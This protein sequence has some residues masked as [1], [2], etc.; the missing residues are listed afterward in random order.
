[1]VSFNEG[2]NVFNSGVYLR[3]GFVMNIDGDYLSYCLETK[4]LNKYR[5]LYWHLNQTSNKQYINQKT[6]SCIRDSVNL[7]R[8]DDIIQPYLVKYD[9]MVPASIVVVFDYQQFADQLFVFV[10]LTTAEQG[11][12]HTTDARSWT[13]G[14]Q[15]MQ[16]V[17]AIT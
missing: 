16:S 11:L 8:N 17:F 5:F 9:A 3:I 13:S 4:Q 15:E 6:A 14:S 7:Y 12:F 2:I 10:P 1:M